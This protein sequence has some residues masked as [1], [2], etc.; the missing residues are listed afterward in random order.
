MSQAWLSW[1][2]EFSLDAA[3]CLKNDGPSCLP[4]RE[5][6]RQRPGEQVTENIL[7]VGNKNNKWN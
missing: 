4:L 6:T 2:G 7:T 5:S 1:D 3:E